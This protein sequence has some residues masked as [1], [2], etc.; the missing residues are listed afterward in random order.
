[1]YKG[2]DYGRGI[3]NI[4]NNGI[5]YGVIPH[6]SIGQIWYEESEPFY[7]EPCCPE[8]GK[9]AF[10]FPTE[11]IKID[12]KLVATPD[13]I[14][15]WEYKEHEC[16]DYCCPFCEYIFGSESAFPEEPYSWFYKSD[17]YEAECSDGID[18]FITKSPYFTYA[19]FCSPC[20][21][22]AIYLLNPLNN[23]ELSNK[24]YCFNHD[25]FE[26]NKAPYP[27]YSVDTGKKI[28]P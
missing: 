2:I 7:G 28:L 21:P 8:C 10:E 27:V 19:Q 24:G 5:R 12:N 17:K 18:I 11:G 9:N 16:G 25:W 13:D 26:N 1:M 22:G 4:D 3:T 20:A 14:D 23:I 15:F 6:H